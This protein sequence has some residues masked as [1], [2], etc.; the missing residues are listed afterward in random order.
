MAGKFFTRQNSD[1]NAQDSRTFKL[2]LHIVGVTAGDI[3]PVTQTVNLPA[4]KVLIANMGR[5]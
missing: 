3:N 1:E 2:S 5:Y 4:Q